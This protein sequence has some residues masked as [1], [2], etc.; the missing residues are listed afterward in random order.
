[1]LRRNYRKTYISLIVSLLILLSCFSLALA[2]PFGPAKID[3]VQ[4]S[5]VAKLYDVP[6]DQF[7][8]P[9]F[10]LNKDNFTTHEEMLNYIY[11]LQQQSDRLQ[12]KILGHS[13]EG[14]PIPLLILN[15]PN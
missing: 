11:N 12:V 1:M 7:T 14:R 10:N 15:K 3:Y 5:Q 4:N 8:T 6:A 2:Q 9:G 13:Q